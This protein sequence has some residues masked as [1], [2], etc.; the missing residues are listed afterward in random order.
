[1]NVPGHI[2]IYTYIHIEAPTV[3]PTS[4]GLAQARPNNNNNNRFGK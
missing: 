2:N 4:V 1:M 3:L